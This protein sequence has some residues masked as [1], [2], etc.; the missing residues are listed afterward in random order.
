MSTA[1]ISPAH[2]AAGGHQP[3]TGAEAPGGSCLVEC[4]NLSRFFGDFAA[5]RRVD[6]GD[7]GAEAPIVSDDE[8]GLLAERFNGMLGGLR[9]R[10]RIRRTFARFVPESVAAA[11]LA[12][13]GL[14]APQEREATVLYA[15]IEDFT[16][17]AS[18]LAPHEI[19]E[20]LN[21]YF[22]E[23]GRIVD[24]HHG[25]I[26][27]FQGDAVLATFN[28]PLAD[29]HHARDAL[30]AAREIDQRLREVSFA[31]SVRLRA[32]IGVS[33]GLLVGGTVG[34]GERLGYTVHGDTVNLAARLEALNKDLGTRILISAR[35]AELTAGTVPLRDRGAVAVRGFEAP[36]RVFEP[37]PASSTGSPREDGRERPLLT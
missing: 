23:I 14:V 3:P 1:P 29:P 15:D 28:L 6:R 27:Q 8:F 22:D 35:T 24:A 31:T 26:T 2:S 18:R 19:L 34:G 30:E 10:D 17:T 20:M 7:S 9:E 13:E 16:R 32:R 5:M 25:V 12:E 4:R 21:A 36:L 33:S 37:G 11:L